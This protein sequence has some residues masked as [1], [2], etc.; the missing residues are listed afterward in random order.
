MTDGQIVIAVPAASPLEVAPE[1]ALLVAA[2][3]PKGPPGDTG[4]TGPTGPAGPTGSTGPTGATGQKGDT[5]DMGPQGPPGISPTGQVATYADLPASPNVL[6]AYVV[7]ADGLLYVYT[8]AWPAEG[9]GYPFR[10]PQ[11]IQG[12]QG[13]TG[14]T[15]ATGAQGEQG[16]QGIQGEQG[17]QGVKGD[18]GEQGDAGVSL[19]IEGH[20]A[21]YA[22]LAALTPAYGQA[23]IV[24]ADGLLYFYDSGFPA[25]GEGVPFRGPQGIQGE[26][27]VQ[28]VKGDQGIQGEQ[29]PKGDPGTTDWD[30]LTNVPTY[31]AAGDTQADARSV[32]GAGTSNL[33]IGTTSGTAC[34]GND[35][36]LS[37]TRTPT[38]GSVTLAKLSATG[39]KDSTTFLRGDNTFAVP[40]SGGANSGVLSSRPAAG[41]AGA[42]YISTD[43]GLLHRD[44]GT[45]WE[46]YGPMNRFY[47]PPA[48]GWSALNSG[49][50]SSDKGDR[51]LSVA[52]DSTFNIRGT[53]RALTPGSEFTAEFYLDFT[54]V[55]ATTNAMYSA[56]GIVLADSVSGKYLL[57]GIGDVSSG[58]AGSS[59]FVESM[60]SVTGTAAAIVSSRS[61]GLGSPPK[62]RRIREDGTTRYYEYSWNRQ[63]WVVFYSEAK[64]TFITADT[65]GLAVL[66]VATSFTAMLRCRSM[67]IS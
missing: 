56:A 60:T 42:L 26:Q 8:T 55:E 10:G 14:A 39:T 31:V 3:G 59:V 49:S 53:A 5:G 18:Q 43:A 54:S 38:D 48:S 37:N 50:A 64:S 34:E 44:T 32:I 67:N 46:T 4:P 12:I 62:W 36:R 57:F 19:D 52:S 41:S 66:N 22:D 20:V 35:S 9:E 33:A 24:D 65:I 45:D 61:F 1:R 25:D 7:T 51:L 2:P 13:A 47:P 21:T 63:D 11:G 58:A 27:G 16:I 17:V 6:D 23:W 29:G 28:G 15:G 40:S 30:A